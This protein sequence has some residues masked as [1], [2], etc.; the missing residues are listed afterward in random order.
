MGIPY[1]LTVTKEL[2]RQ[3][4]VALKVIFHIQNINNQ[5]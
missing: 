5:T 4:K 2:N 1:I 3:Q